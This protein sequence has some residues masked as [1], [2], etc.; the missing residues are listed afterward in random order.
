[1]AAYQQY[2]LGPSGACLCVTP[3][4]FVLRSRFPPC[5]PPSTLPPSPLSAGVYCALPQPLA[6]FASDLKYACSL[7]Q[8]GC[9]K[10]STH[11]AH[12]Y[13]D[14]GEGSKGKEAGGP[15]RPGRAW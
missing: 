14:K 11:Y 3:I 2:G 10:S 7:V 5:H 12:E 8:A 13:N 1:M 6:A 15:A 9:N 4:V